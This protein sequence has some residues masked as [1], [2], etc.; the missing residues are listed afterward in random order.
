MFILPLLPLEEVWCTPPFWIYVRHPQED[1]C[2]GGDEQARGPTTLI[3]ITTFCQD[4]AI[5]RVGWLQYYVGW[6]V[7]GGRC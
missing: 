1:V 2:V 6:Y 4:R 3:V 5:R 7:A